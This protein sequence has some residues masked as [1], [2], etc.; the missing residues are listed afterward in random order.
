M[1]A[2]WLVA[3]TCFALGAFCADLALMLI[4]RHPV[5]KRLKYTPDQIKIMI[6][7]DAKE[8][9]VF[10]EEWLKNDYRGA[11]LFSGIAQRFIANVLDRSIPKLREEPEQ[12][13][14]ELGASKMKE[15]D[16]EGRDL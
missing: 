10:I 4:N 2:A 11:K 9:D 7:T 6:E 8:T 1:N 14:Q 3:G 5:S 15:L 16:E 13:L 12:H